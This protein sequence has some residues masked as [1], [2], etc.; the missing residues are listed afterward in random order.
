M[1]LGVHMLDIVLHLL[2]EPEVRTVT[3]A[4]YA[5]FGPRGR[6]G[7]VSTTMTK[8][9]VTDGEFDV[10]DLSTAFL[11]LDGGA[12]PAAGVQL[13]PVGARGPVL[14]QRLRRRRRGRDRLGSGARR[15]A[16]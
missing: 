9:G 13:G 7:S 10:E 2:D 8:T 5:E 1:D 16:R 3:A 12:D 4:T 6:G 15:S 11:R 14:R